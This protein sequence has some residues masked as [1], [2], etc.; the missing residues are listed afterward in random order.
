MKPIALPIGQCKTGTSR[1]LF[2][3]GRAGEARVLK[4][5]HLEIAHLAIGHRRSLESDADLAVF[6]SLLSV[7]GIRFLG[8]LDIRAEAVLL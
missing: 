2:I 1:L 3:A 8:Q 5:S 4:H 7:A 6:S